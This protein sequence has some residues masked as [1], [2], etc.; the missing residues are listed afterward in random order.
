[1]PQNNHLI[2]VWMPDS[3]IG[4]RWGE[5]RKQIK[6]HQSCK[7]LLEWQ[8]SGRGCVNFFLP[9]IYRWTGFWTKHFS[10]TA[11][12]RVKV[13]LSKPLWM[14]IITEAIKNKSKKQ[15]PTWSQNW[16]LLCNSAEKAMATHSSTLAWRIP[17]TMEPGELLSMGSHR[18]GHD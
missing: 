9:A 6:S 13:L 16:L 3:F 17:G 2:G 18:V 1:M 8:A 11:W 4:Q 12:Q 14:I 15:F 5:V 10:L 7:H